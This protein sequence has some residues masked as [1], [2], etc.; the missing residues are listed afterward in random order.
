MLVYAY[1]GDGTSPQYAAIEQAIRTTQFVRNKCLRLWVEADK[2]HPVK[3]NDLQA[4]CRQ[5][6]KD[7]AFA[8]TLNA[9]ARQAAADR[10]WAAISRFDDNCKTKKLGKKGYPRF[11][12]DGRSVEYKVTGWPEGK[13]IRFTDGCGLGRLRMIGTRQKHGDQ[14]QNKPL[15]TPLSF[16]VQDIKR[17]RLVRRAA[18]YYVQFCSDTVRNVVQVPTGMQRGID[19]GRQEF[20]IDSEGQTAANPRFLRKMEATIKRRQRTVAKNYDPEK[21]KTKQPQSHN[22]KQAVKRL[23]KAHLKG[24]RQREDVARKAASTLV[25]SSDV[26]AVEDLQIATMVRNHSLAKSIADAAWGRFLHWVRSY[27]SLHGIPVI[28]VPPQYTSQRWS[29]SL[30]NGHPCDQIV[31]KTLSTRTHGW[32]QC[33]LVLDR[34]HHAA[35][36]VLGLAL[37]IMAHDSTVG[38]TGTG[39]PASGQKRLG[40]ADQHPGTSNGIAGASG[41]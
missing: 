28:A 16:P 15:R 1:K 26:L 6:A 11:Q 20:Y 36:L 33:G 32:P 21:R 31:W 9:Q 3:A 40:S 12:H 7:F 39:S 8:A 13:H 35:R 14:Q 24:Q 29:G 10:A 2:A 19:I 37:V 30:P 17:V 25:Q 23:A 22:Y 18:G 27:G 5:L 34:D 41:R 4:Y 38:Q